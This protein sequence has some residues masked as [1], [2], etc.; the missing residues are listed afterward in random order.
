MAERTFA[1]DVGATDIVVSHVSPK[2]AAEQVAQSAKYGP[3]GSRGMAAGPP[4]LRR[5]QLLINGV[6]LL[7]TELGDRKTNHFML[8]YFHAPPSQEMKRRHSPRDAST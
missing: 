3:I 2:A 1:L 8:V 7:E 4:V 5:D 6:S